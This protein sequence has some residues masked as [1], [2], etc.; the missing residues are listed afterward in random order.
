MAGT[1]SPADKVV[2]GQVLPPLLDG[3][4]GVGG[5][6]GV[7]DLLTDLDDLGGEPERLLPDRDPPVVGVARVVEQRQGRVR[8]PADPPHSEPFRTEPVGDVV[9][10][11]GGDLVRVVVGDA[12]EVVQQL[13]QEHLG[14]G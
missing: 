14:V 10:L 12:H 11:G 5:R 3:G 9:L 4:R 8:G 13:G 2:L 6:V 7:G 1:F